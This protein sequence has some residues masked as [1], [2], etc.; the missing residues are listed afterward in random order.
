MARPWAAVRAV[1]GTPAAPVASS[2]IANERSSSTMSA[3]GESLG[4]LAIAAILP[5]ASGGQL[6]GNVSC[7]WGADHAGS[8]VSRRGAG[9]VACRVR[10]RAGRGAGPCA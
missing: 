5:Q 3:V 9:C 1:A 10:R 4:T 6:M 2:T 7:I 8:G